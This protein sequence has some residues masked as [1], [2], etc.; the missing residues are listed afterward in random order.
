MGLREEMQGFIDG[1]GLATPSPCAPGTIKG[2]DN[3]PMYFSEYIVM[4]DKLGQLTDQDKADFVSRI[5]A[6]INP[7]GMLNRVPVGQFDGQEGPDDYYGVLNACKQ[8]GITSIPRQ[9]LKSVFKYKGALNNVS[10]GTWSWKSLLI[11][12]LQLIACMVAAAFPSFSNPLHFCIRLLAMPFFLVA[13]ISIAISCIGENTDSTDP[14]RLSWH[15]QNTLKPVSLLC[16]LSS[17]LWL[18]RLYKDY[19]SEGMKGVAAIYYYP[20]GNHPFARYWVT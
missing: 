10:P 20:Q 15:V 9:L 12:Q 14:R 7:E 16:W 5:G 2:S 6:C 17:K 19:G 13:A 4:L 3:G 8:L 18:S 1:N 11:R